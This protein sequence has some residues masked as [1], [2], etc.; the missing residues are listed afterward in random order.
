M[1]S[2]EEIEDK[3]I[4]T[5]AKVLKIMKSDLASFAKSTAFSSANLLSLD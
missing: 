1:A 3:N 5:M 4:V 2:S